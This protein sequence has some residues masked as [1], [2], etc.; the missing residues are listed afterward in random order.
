MPGPANTGVAMG[1]PMG[2]PPQMPGTPA[3]MTMGGMTGGSGGGQLADLMAANLQKLRLV[4]Q[5]TEQIAT[6]ME[7]LL[8]EE[9]RNPAGGNL[10]NQQGNRQVK[11]QEQGDG[12]RQ[13]QG[14]RS[15]RGRKA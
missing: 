5:E 10:G 13:R 1:T 14:P 7:E 9:R 15:L 8:N 3:M 6:Q 2:M 4:L 12:G 11:R